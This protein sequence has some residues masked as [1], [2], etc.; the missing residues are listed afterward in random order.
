MISEARILRPALD[1][2]SA[3]SGSSLHPTCLFRL[4]RSFRERRLDQGRATRNGAPSSYPPAVLASRTG[5][6]FVLPTGTVTMLFTDI[7]GSTRL[8]QRLAERYGVLLEEHH[9]ILRRA[10]AANNGIETGTAGD[11][12][13]VAFGEAHDAIEAAIEA[14]RALC[15]HSWPDGVECRV[16]MGLHTGKP[17][18]N[19]DGYFGIDLHRGSRIADAGHGGQILLSAV[20]AQLIG[21]ELPA[22]ARLLRLGEQMLKGFDHPECIYQLVVEGLSS[23]FPQLRAQAATAA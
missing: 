22:G 2:N 11:A 17:R 19:A 3:P 23:V 13:F 6:S 5:R 4:K 18:R 7:E 14:Q 15:A 8:V 16:R 9:R 12:F 20:T 21:E 1:D 10:F